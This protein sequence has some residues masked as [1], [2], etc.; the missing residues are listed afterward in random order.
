MKRTFFFI[1]II[2][3]FAA[4]WVG[5]L[6]GPDIPANNADGL[7]AY[8]HYYEVAE[9]IIGKDS[10]TDDDVKNYVLAQKQLEDYK[11]GHIM[12]WPEICDQRDK[13]SDI[14]RMYAKEENNNIMKYVKMY[15]DDP[16]LLKNWAY[17]Y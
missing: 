13:L 4:F 17:S 8:Q 12:T 5:K 15:F 10:V 1:S 7:L 16:S 2:C 11:A 3:I 14:I 9:Q 6:S